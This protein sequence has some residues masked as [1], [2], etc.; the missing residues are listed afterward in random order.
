LR[1]Q[2]HFKIDKIAEAYYLITSDQNINFP[3]LANAILMDEKSNFKYLSASRDELCVSNEMTI[4]RLSNYLKS[5]VYLPIKSQIQELKVCF[6]K[7]VDWE[8]VEAVT[9]L[10]KEKYIQKLLASKLKV[11]MTGFYP[12][13]IYLEGLDKNLW[14]PRKSVPRLKVQEG[15]FAV[16]GQYAGIYNLQSPGG[17]SIIGTC[18]QH[19][20]DVANTPPIPWKIGDLI[21]IQRIPNT[22]LESNDRKLS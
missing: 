13:F 22:E 20:W 10:T 11:S 12:G 3:L 2:N 17:W 7:G 8:E 5:L 9:N 1:R 14:V 15:S 16:G 21:S 4:Q 19:L 18:E 6:E